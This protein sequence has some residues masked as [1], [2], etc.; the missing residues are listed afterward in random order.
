MVSD[1]SEIIDSSEDGDANPNYKLSLNGEKLTMKEETKTEAEPEGSMNRDDI[2]HLLKKPELK[3]LGASN[4]EEQ[5]EEL[6]SPLRRP[7]KTTPGFS[8]MAL[9]N[10]HAESKTEV[11]AAS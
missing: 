11:D 10:Q 6:Q 7:S 1:E 8:L 3:V 4:R 5:T 9:L 2:A